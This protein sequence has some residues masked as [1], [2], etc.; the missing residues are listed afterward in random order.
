M[1]SIASEMQCAKSYLQGRGVTPT[2]MRCETKG[3]SPLP[4][5][6]PSAEVPILKGHL[7]LIR[8]PLGVASGRGGHAGGRG[9][10]LPHRVDAPLVAGH[11]VRDLA[12]AVD[13]GVA[14]VDVGRA[15]VDL[16]AHNVHPL[17]H[18]R[19]QRRFPLA[20]YSQRAGRA[21]KPR[22][23]GDRERGGAHL[24]VPHGL[25]EREVL[26]HAARA[27]GRVLARL[28][29]RPAVLLHLLRGQ[30]V[31]VRL[32]LPANRAQSRTRRHN[33]CA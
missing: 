9:G 15:H 21:R 19:S 7:Y 17:V 18:L 20:G 26:L 16:G 1:P 3:E 4:F 11:L 10:G 5:A 30:R 6:G 12:H 31:D 14:H 32:A 28:L 29:E 22:F 24:A 2:L 13:G 33:R 8:P 27:V 23:R 25:E